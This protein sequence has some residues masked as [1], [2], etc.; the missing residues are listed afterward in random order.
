MKPL[1]RVMIIVSFVNLAGAQLAALRV[2]RGLRDLGHDPKVVFLYLQTTIDMPDHAFE[3]LLP[4]A[5]PGPL[6]YLRILRDLARMM[7]Q[8]RPD[9]VLTFLPFAN[10]LGQLVALSA[11]VRKRIVSHRF[12]IYTASPIMRCLD[13]VWAWFGVYTRVVAVSESVR[14]TCRRYPSW[15]RDRIV[16]VHNG[17]REWRSSTLTRQDARRRFGIAEGNFVLV[18]VG[19]LSRE[20]NYPFMLRCVQQ[21]ENVILLIA[22]TGGLR[23]D[24]EHMLAELGLGAKVR[25]LGNLAHSEIPDLLAAA[26]VFIQ[27]SIYEGHSNSILEA[28]HAGIPIMAPDIPAQREMLTSA[29]GKTAGALLPLGNIHSWVTAIER[30]RVDGSAAQEAREAALRRGKVFRYDAMI[31]GFDR[32]LTDD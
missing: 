2:A 29:D 18:A 4:R 7:R 23:S 12:P 16:V 17:L 19:R 31:A 26:D 21:L 20:K 14:A 22:G 25:L 28:L 9:C 8:E 3:I 5:K 15:L 30:L 24:L 27:T 10:V 13:L 6:G 32:V 1:Q 11:G